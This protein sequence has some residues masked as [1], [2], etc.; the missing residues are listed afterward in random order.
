MEPGGT[1]SSS[2]VNA[3]ERVRRFAC[4]SCGK[5]CDAG[6]EMELSEA[7][8]L[9]DKFILSLCLG[10]WRFPLLSSSDQRAR[11]PGIDEAA[12][13]DARRHIGI[14]SVRDETD[15]ARAQSVHLTISAAPI[16][17]QQGQC[18][19]LVDKRCSIY[20]SRPNACR[21]VPLH[22]TQPLSQ[23]GP[24]LDRFVRM[25]G[26]LCDTSAGAPVLLSGGRVMDPEILQARADALILV[27]AN[28]G[29]KNELL[30]LM[31]D[32]DVARAAGLP[33][34]E[35]VLR[36]AE[37][38]GRVTMSMLVAWR[39]ARNVGIISPVVF[40]EAC[41]RQIAL[42][43]EELERGADAALAARLARLLAEYEAAYARAQRQA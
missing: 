38:G 37:A 6:P 40:V 31:D 11:W 43:K 17:R 41:E 19:A 3:H 8:A 21:A 1:S 39:V 15:S 7:T 30:A 20:E 18:P 4:T 42:L 25:P 14:F 22:F 2:Q 35:T 13:E 5:C 12:L 33:S 10:V 28:Q 9:A 26:H 36:Q 32:A 24:T 16:D 29:W 23:L 27:K 34:Y